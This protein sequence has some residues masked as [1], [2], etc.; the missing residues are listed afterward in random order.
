MIKILLE[1][2]F[3]KVID[4]SHFTSSKRYNNLETRLEIL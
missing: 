1:N 2:V 4:K 3:V